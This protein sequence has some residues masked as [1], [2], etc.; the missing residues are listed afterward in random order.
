LLGVADAV[1]RSVTWRT[2]WSVA[3]AEKG[4]A[5]RIE[6]AARRQLGPAAFDAAYADGA[7]HAW[8]VVDE[9]RRAAR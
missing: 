8:D 5:E 7:A 1:R 2:G 3:S 6:H 9:L 4:D